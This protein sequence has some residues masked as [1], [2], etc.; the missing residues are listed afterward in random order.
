L[1]DDDDA[2]LGG[3]QTLQFAMATQQLQPIDLSVTVERWPTAGTFTIA[4]GSRTEA[5]VVVARLQRGDVVGLGEA[6]PYARY[7]ESVDGVVQALQAQAL[8]LQQGMNRRGLLLAMPAGAA[9]NALDAALWALESRSVGQP[10]WALAGLPAPRP[11]TT[12]FT[13]SLGTPDQMSAAAAAAAHR[14][15]LK[16]KLGGAGD[17]E[18]I[19]AVRAA[20][21]QSTLVVDANEAWTEANL[22]EHLQACA[23]AQVALIEQPL[24]ADADAAL[25]GLSSPVPLC[26]DESF[27]G[28]DSLDVVA[29]RYQFVNLKLDKTGGLTAAIDVARAA[30]ARG[31]G[32]MVGCMVGTSLAMAPAFVLAP[33]AQFVDL[34]GPLLLQ[35]DRV[36]AFAYEGSTMLPARPGVWD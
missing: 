22:H 19:A 16:V 21:P 7:G 9:R 11:V 25:Q 18:R 8:A 26:A 10:V 1:Q 28:L 20:A 36:P 2:D 3:Q 31:L 35:R 33:W 5:V 4:R 6:V 15:L 27:H 12:A 14:P 13:L 23:D 30:R 17:L 34:D 24:P 29:R 32:L